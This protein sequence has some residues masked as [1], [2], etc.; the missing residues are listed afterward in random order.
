MSSQNFLN[1]EPDCIWLRI[2]SMDATRCN[3]IA[4]SAR[5]CAPENFQPWNFL[6]SE[7]P[8]VWLLA[9]RK[10]TRTRCFMWRQR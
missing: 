3:R 6:F 2:S 8:K 1:L 4:G 5:W 7:V 10:G 9:S